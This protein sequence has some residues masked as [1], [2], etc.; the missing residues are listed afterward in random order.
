MLKGSARTQPDPQIEGYLKTGILVLIVGFLGGCALV[1]TPPDAEI[2]LSVFFLDVEQGSSILIVSPSGVAALIDAG[3]GQS[4]DGPSDAEPVQCIRD[5]AATIKGFRL[6][7]IIATHFDADHIGKLDDVLMASP[8]VVSPDYRLYTRGSVGTST[9]SGDSYGYIESI[10]P[11]HRSDIV[12]NDV[13]DL[14]AGVALTC[15]AADGKYVAGGSVQSVSLSS[16]DENGRSV[17]VILSFHEVKMWFGGDLVR[18]VEEA[19]A[20]YLPD[21]EVYAVDHHG[22]SGSSS[23]AFLQALRPEYAICQS[24]QENG[25]GH[26]SKNAVERILSVAA[27]GGGKPLFLQQNRG[28]PDDSRSDDSLAAG[29]ADPDGTGPLAGNI[30]VVTDGYSVTITWP[31]H[32]TTPS[33]TTHESAASAALSLGSRHVL[34]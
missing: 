19:V 25:Y 5:I 17:A 24:G 29:I 15:F 14:G 10:G 28:N 3:T 23:L 32:T 8:A 1:P 22:A 31:G 26:P 30:E 7:H 16:N 9:S 13:I 21:V 34:P 18:V 20:Q 6:R 4:G 11:D 12:P 33:E 2:T 27:S